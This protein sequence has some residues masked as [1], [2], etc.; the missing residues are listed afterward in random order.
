MKP[1]KPFDFLL[2]LLHNDAF[3]KWAVL[4]FRGAVVADCVSLRADKRDYVLYL[5]AIKLSSLPSGSNLRRK[6][7]CGEVMRL[8]AEVWRHDRRS[9]VIGEWTKRHGSGCMTLKAKFLK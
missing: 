8:E 9:E 6:R 1:R 4:P 3:G 5:P 7:A 2:V